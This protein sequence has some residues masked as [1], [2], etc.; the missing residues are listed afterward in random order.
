MGSGQINYDFVALQ[1]KL[2]NFLWLYSYVNVSYFQVELNH[3]H[4]NSSREQLRKFTI[5]SHAILM[6][7]Q[8]V[9]TCAFVRSRCSLGA[10]E[11]I[12]RI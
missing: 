11:G 3:T 2:D 12:N 10:K 7:I 6:S 1:S 9:S 8:F 4:R 5:K